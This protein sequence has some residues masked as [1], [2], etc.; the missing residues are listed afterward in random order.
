MMMFAGFGVSLRDMPSYLYWGTYTSYLRFGL[1]GYV[2][3]IYGFN[4]STLGCMKE[5]Y[6]HY[7]YPKKFLAEVAMDPTQVPI[8]IM[9]LAAMVL[10]L[11][12][13][14][15]PLLRWKLYAMR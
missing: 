4:R 14:V 9:A 5:H 6:C 7:R 2:G 12:A 10:I 11:R 3:T 1:E 15:Y 8:D 13:V